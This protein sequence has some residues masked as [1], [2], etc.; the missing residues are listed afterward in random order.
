MAAFSGM[1][2]CIEGGKDKTFSAQLQIFD[3]YEKI[4]RHKPKNSIKLDNAKIESSY[5]S[6]AGSNT[7]S[8]AYTST[9]L[10]SQGGINI[11]S[12][13]PSSMGSST[14]QSGSTPSLSVDST[15]GSIPGTNGVMDVYIFTV[16]T[17]SGELHEFRTDSENDRLRWVKL[18]QLLVMYP[19]SQI[20]EEPKVNPIKDSFRHSL[21]AKQYNAGEL[22]FNSVGSCF[23][24]NC[25]LLNLV[26]ILL[27][28][29]YFEK[30]VWGGGEEGIW[31][32]LGLS[33]IFN[34]GQVAVKCKV[35][36][37]QYGYVDTTSPMC[38]F[39]IEKYF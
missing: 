1:G 12:S 34:S 16:A 6:P 15:S 33:V 37:V 36:C 11:S 9:I 24:I 31:V 28:L 19:Y 32:H 13:P 26:C 20:P 22:P 21:E 7:S 18:L 29:L 5:S 2:N 25:L 3:D 8:P 4:E 14:S 23:V 10:T 35:L 39:N 38:I 30:L 27:M 17:S